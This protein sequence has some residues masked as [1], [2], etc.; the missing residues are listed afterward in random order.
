[1]RCPL[2]GRYE[3]QSGRD[4]DIASRSRLHPKATWRDGVLLQRQP[5][6]ELRFLCTVA[7]WQQRWLWLTCY[8]DLLFLG[9]GSWVFARE[10]FGGDDVG[11]TLSA[12]H[13]SVGVIWGSLAR[14]LELCCGYGDQGAT[15]TSC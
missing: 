4:A 9:A 10:L 12:Y 2:F 6:P 8:D 7:R 11:S 1:V 3:E 14:S 13:H 15:R 5:A